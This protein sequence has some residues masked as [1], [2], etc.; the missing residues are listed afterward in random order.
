MKVLGFFA[1]FLIAAWFLMAFFDVRASGDVIRAYSATK[2]ADGS[3]AKPDLLPLAITAYRVA[4]TYVVTGGISPTKI[5]DCEI[6]NKANWKCRFSDKSATFGARE[7]QFFS[8]SN[9]E[10]Y[11]H[12]ATMDE[13]V[14]M[15][16]L[17][18]MMLSCAWDWHSGPVQ[19]LFGC[20]LRPFFE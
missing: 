6:F 16:R 7:G 18:Y 9:T 11:P 3:E 20:S 5:D 2:T 1:G 10:L 12:L 14:F 8:V 19:F 17:G 15:P 13:E 4:D